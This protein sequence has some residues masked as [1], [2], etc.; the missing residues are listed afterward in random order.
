MKKIYLN[1]GSIGLF[2]CL[3][4]FLII[5]CSQ[6]E[7]DKETKADITTKAKTDISFAGVNYTVADGVVYLSGKC[8]TDKAK[9]SVEGTVKDIAGVKNV[10]NTISIA[11]VVL[12]SD[13]A[14]KQSV[15]SVLKNYAGVQADVRDS[16]VVVKGEA[17][18]KDMQKLM[19]GLYSLNAKKIENELGVR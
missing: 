16:M 17:E 6:Q 9:T 4:N 13:Y 3:L 12:T 7:I 15:D 5:S 8:P 2:I 10:V 14:L 11:P 18:K 1:R 19:E